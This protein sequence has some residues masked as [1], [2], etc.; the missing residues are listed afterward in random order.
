VTRTQGKRRSAARITFTLSAPGRVVFVVRGP[1]PSCGV[2]GRFSVRGK[3]GRNRVRFT[4]RVGR[5]TLG[6]GAYRITARTRTSAATRP[7]VV[8]IEPGARSAFRCGESGTA[9]PEIFASLSGGF[10]SSGAEPGTAAKSAAGSSP[11]RKTG[12]SQDDAGSGVLPAVKDGLSK[13]PEALPNLQIPSD[14][15]SPSSIIGLGALLLLALSGL[16][17]LLYVVRFLRGP[18]TT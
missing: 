6:P 15:S 14:S 3:R 13:I 18:H 16:A 10:T 9:G 12:D 7:V 2:V 8:V 4:G 1:A 17:L 5:R 11:P